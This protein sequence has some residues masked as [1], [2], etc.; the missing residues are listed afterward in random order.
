[1]QDIAK[2]IPEAELRLYTLKDEKFRKGGVILV[3]SSEVLINLRKD[4]GSR[5]ELA[6]IWS[7]G[8]EFVFFV[9]HLLEAEWEAA[10]NRFELKNEIILE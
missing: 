1:M 8:K 6:A 2:Q 5:E 3:D 10:S 9:K 7:N 4:A